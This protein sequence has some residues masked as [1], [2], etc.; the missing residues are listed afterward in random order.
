MRAK[1]YEENLQPREE[2]VEFERHLHKLDGV[3][4]VKVVG[5]ARPA[6]IYVVAST[7]R[8]D[9]EIIRE[10]QRL[11]VDELGIV[12][13][14]RAILLTRMGEEVHKASSFRPVLE[15]VVTANMRDSTWVKVVLTW[16]DGDS[17]EGVA[18][19]S[20]AR[21]ERAAGAVAAAVLALEPILGPKGIKL[22]TDHVLVSQVGAKESVVV[23]S[24]FRSDES[25]TPV[26]GSALAHDDL[27]SAAVRALLQSI[28]RKLE[29]P[30]KQPAR[31]R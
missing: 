5:V 28:N 17:T 19:V 21:E 25:D 8:A 7:D 24:T 11:G 30:G 3:S 16:P 22:H 1:G 23:A 2:I 14:E 15:R 13:D 27:A 10:I 20:P 26:V 9:E 6:R 18:P 29:D 31:A 4:Q 12:I